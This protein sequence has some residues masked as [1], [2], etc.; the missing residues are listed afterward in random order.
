LNKWPAIWKHEYI[1]SERHSLRIFL[2]LLYHISTYH[3]FFSDHW[4]AI[5]AF[6]F[7]VSK[8]MHIKNAFIMHSEKAIVAQKLFSLF[9]SLWGPKP[10]GPSEIPLWLFSSNRIFKSHFVPPD[11]LC[12]EVAKPP[13]RWPS[14]T[15]GL[16]RLFEK[17]AEK[18]V[19]I[20][21]DLWKILEKL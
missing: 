6:F 19:S 11:R 14:C 1:I 3:I 17:F 8:I 5:V 16:S 7:H 9:F 20:L 4:L 10:S 2:V 18:S 21:D 15:F 12:T 13:A